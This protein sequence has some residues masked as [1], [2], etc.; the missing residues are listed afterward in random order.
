MINE[1]S[2]DPINSQSFVEQSKGNGGIDSS[3][4]K[5]EDT[6]IAD[7][8]YNFLLQTFMH[9]IQLPSRGRATIQEVLENFHAV[10]GMRY[11]GMEL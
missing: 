11:F 8:F 9:I 2:I 5:N 10:F 1:Q 3:R 6:A 4:Y 7:C